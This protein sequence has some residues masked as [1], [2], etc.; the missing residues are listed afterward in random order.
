MSTTPAEIIASALQLP[1]AERAKVVDVLQDS[2]VDDTLD[3]GPA[4]PPDEVEAAWNAE[5][6]RRLAEV[7]DGGVKTVLADEAERMIRGDGR[8]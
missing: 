3:H 5:I 6:A 2:L 8:P 1:I 7:D 4:D